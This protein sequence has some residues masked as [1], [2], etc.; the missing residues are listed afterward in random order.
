MGRQ[1][2]IQVELD[3][4]LEHCM[5]FMS[6]PGLYEALGAMEGVAYHRVGGLRDENGFR[7][8]QEEIGL[9]EPLPSFL[10]TL[11]P[12]QRIAWTQRFAMDLATLEFIF[13]VRHAVPAY[14]LEV[15]G[16]GCFRALGPEKCRYEL[17]IDFE[18]RFPLFGRRIE[19]VLSERARPMLELDARIRRTYIE[20]RRGCPP[21]VVVQPPHRSVATPTPPSMGRLRPVWP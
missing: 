5:A 11:L 8:W 6:D 1:V 15:N 19:Q 20:A 9:E 21:P 3:V 14:V 4:N 10:Q 7:Y 16:G 12:P 17:E 2:G 18:S 13:D